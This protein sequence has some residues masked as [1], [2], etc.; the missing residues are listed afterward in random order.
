MSVE[1]QQSD[2][3]NAPKTQIQFI[4][5]V[6]K[7]VLASIECDC[8]YSSFLI[9]DQCPTCKGNTRWKIV[10]WNGTIAS[11][12]VV[13]VGPP[14]LMDITPYT[15]AIVDFGRNLRISAI[16]N[17]KFDINNPPVDLIGKKV[18]PKILER[19]NRKIIGVDLIK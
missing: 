12:C 3:E 19:P 4:N 6:N 8:G 16:V 5:F 18:A 14:E 10:N 9:S 13:Y 15:T 2:L 7:G 1:V 17:T 11:Y